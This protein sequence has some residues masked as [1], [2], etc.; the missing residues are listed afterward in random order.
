MP[1]AA[2]G[3]MR[4]CQ[5]SLG[6]RLPAALEIELKNAIF[7]Q[8]RDWELRNI[9]KSLQGY[10]ERLKAGGL[11]E[12]LE[13]GFEGVVPGLEGMDAMVGC[14]RC[15]YALSDWDEVLA[16]P[17]PNPNPNW[18]EVLA[19]PNP[20]PN[21]D[22]VLALAE[23]AWDTCGATE[24]AQFAKVAAMA[25]MNMGEWDAMAPFALATPPEGT[26]AFLRAVLEVRNLTLTLTLILT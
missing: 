7:H 20:N 15:H 23:R 22:E 2:V 18:D 14:I 4:Y 24:R 12:S 1:D 10:T 17:N 9:R 8:M 21:W 6:L 3:L 25:A 11:R 16:N 19:N 5:G 26:G 13:G